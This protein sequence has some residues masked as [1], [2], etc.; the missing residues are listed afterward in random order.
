MR[1]EQPFKAPIHPLP[2]LAVSADEKIIRFNNQLLV[3]DW[4]DELI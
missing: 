1:Y 4:A 2:I 3:F